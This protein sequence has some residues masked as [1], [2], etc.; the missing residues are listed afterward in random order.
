MHQMEEDGADVDHHHFVD[1]D[2]NSPMEYS[3]NVDFCIDFLR[4]FWILSDKMNL[5]IIDY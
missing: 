4:Y 3:L 1:M 5:M 2:R